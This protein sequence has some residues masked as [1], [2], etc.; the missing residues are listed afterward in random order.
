MTTSVLLGSFCFNTSGQGG[1]RLQRVYGHNC[2][3]T[4]LVLTLS[5][6]ATLLSRCMF[7]GHYILRSEIRKRYI[8]R[9]PSR[10]PTSMS[11]CK[12]N[13]RVAAYPP[14]CHQYIHVTTVSPRKLLRDTT[15]V[16]V[17]NHDLCS[18]IKI[19]GETLLYIIFGLI[20]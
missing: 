18:T 9:F 10:P 1:Q 8:L 12:Q 5:L 3:R 19:R 6:R 13:C 16:V 11:S 14:L 4:R 7:I 15:R 17:P 2:A 20:F